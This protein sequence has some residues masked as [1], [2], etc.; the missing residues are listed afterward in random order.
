LNFIEGKPLSWVYF[1]ATLNAATWGAE[2]I[3]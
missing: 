2:I 1:A 3:D